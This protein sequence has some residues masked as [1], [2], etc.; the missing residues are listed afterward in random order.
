MHIILGII[1]IIAGSAITIY[2]EKI[3][4]T[5]GR[6]PIFEKYLGFEGGS[7]LGYKLIGI[8]VFFIS[9]LILLNMHEG[10]LLWILSPLLRP[11]MRNM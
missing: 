4:N 5:F 6:I 2:S 3:L 9:T 1:G 8:V 7:R 10:F 11:A